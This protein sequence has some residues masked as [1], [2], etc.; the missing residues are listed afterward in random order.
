MFNQ[1]RWELSREVSNRKSMGEASE[2]GTL[3]K[4]KA[5]LKAQLQQS[6]IERENLQKQLDWHMSQRRSS[7]DKWTPYPTMAKQFSDD[8]DNDDARETQSV[9]KSTHSATWPLDTP[10]DQIKK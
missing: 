4:E 1:M 2:L 8:D 10:Q 3:Q 9:V 6:S 5:L 7:M